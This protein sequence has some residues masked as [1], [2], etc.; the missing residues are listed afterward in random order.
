MN[1][2][3]EP[4]GTAARPPPGFVGVTARGRLLGPQ[5]C[6]PARWPCAAACWW[7]RENHVQFQRV[8][9]VIVQVEHLLDSQVEPGRVIVYQR[10]LWAKSLIY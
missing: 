3:K 2:K 4:L 7:D 8:E 9:H 1:T 5:G 10:A 6:G